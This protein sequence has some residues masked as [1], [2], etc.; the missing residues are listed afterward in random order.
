MAEAENKGTGAQEDDSD[1]CPDFFYFCKRA[2]AQVRE[3]IKNGEKITEDKI[4]ELVSPENLDDNEIMVPVDMGGTDFD[5]VEHMVKELGP[6]GAAKELVKCADKFEAR[7]NQLQDD[8]DEGP[9]EM[10][11]KEWRAV[12]EEDEDDEEGEEEEFPEDDEDDD[13]EDPTP[14]P[15]KAKLS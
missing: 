8:E 4:G 12:L 5:D 13:D 15:K 9:M 2:L 14:S 6:E 11:A 7:N 3:M 10:T 1:D